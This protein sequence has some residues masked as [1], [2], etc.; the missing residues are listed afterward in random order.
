MPFTWNSLE[1]IQALANIKER[2]Y[3]KPQLIFKH[4]TSCPLSSIA[5]V[6]LESISSDL[7]SRIE[8]HYLDLLAYRS[9][10]N[11]IAEDY[12][13]HHESPQVIIIWE[14]E[15][16]YDESHLDIEGNDIQHHLDFLFE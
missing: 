11:Y 10:S 1:S 16:T 8:F 4:S 2:S 3:V 15:A 12:A 6:R 5:K 13:V 7:F 9:V 14:G